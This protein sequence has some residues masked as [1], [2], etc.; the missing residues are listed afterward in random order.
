MT[1]YGRCFA[2]LFACA[3]SAGVAHSQTLYTEPDQGFTPIYNFI[4]TATKTLDMTMYEFVDTTAEKDLA[5]LAKKGVVVRVILDQNLEKSSNTTAYNYLNANGCTAVWANPTYH[6][7]HQKTITVDGK[8]SMI[9]SANLTSEY[10]SSTRD[11]AYTDVN[12][13]DVEEIEYVFGKD[14]TSSSVT[15]TA[16]ADLIWSPNEATTA[17]TN[18]ID[19]ASHTL[20]VESEEMSDATIVTA[21]E[22]RAK[23]GVKVTVIMT[24]TDDDYETEFEALTKAGVK[25]YTYASNAS[26]YIHAK[27]MVADETY[28]DAKAFL[29]SENFSDDSLTENRELG[30][31]ITTTSVITS[32][33]NTLTS[34]ANGGTLW[35]KT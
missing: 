29:G 19:G 14:F 12:A 3:L 8:T 18:F 7:T 21:L 16:G 11:F 4:H 5:A 10:Y 24:N 32:L 25:V 33:G 17:L 13:T 22:N 1:R 23:A 15:P 9:L 6:A 28:S 31:T 35:T 27:V 34:D 20:L 2:A 30:L 26:L